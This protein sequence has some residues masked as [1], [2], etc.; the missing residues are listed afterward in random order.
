M[1]NIS[2]Y[3]RSH[4]NKKFD[5]DK[6]NFYFRGNIFYKNNYICP[7]ELYN[8]LSINLNENYIIEISKKLNGFYSWI[9]LNEKF[10]FLSVDHIRSLPLFYLIKNNYIFI[11]DETDWIR[12]HNNLK[13]IEES[14]EEE[15]KLSGLVSGRQTLFKE[16]RQLCP[17]EIL[18]INRCNSNS[19]LSREFFN[20]K[21]INDSYINKIELLNQLEEKSDK[22]FKRLI[23]FAKNRKIVIPLSGGYDSRLVAIKIKELGY[24]NVLTYSYGLRGNNDSEISKKVAK[25]LGFEWIFIKYDKNLWK[26]YWKD[27]Q[28]LK[29]QIW[30]SGFSSIPGIQEFPAIHF[31]KYNNIVPQDAL[32][33]PGHTGDFISGKHLPSFNKDEKF[34]NNNILAEIIFDKYYSNIPLF[35]LQNNKKKYWCKKILKSFNTINTKDLI[36]LC[37]GFESW[38]WKER[39]SKFIVNS[40]RTYEYF[41]FDWWLPLWDKEFVDFWKG[42]SLKYRYNQK[43][44]KVY[45][46]SK[47]ND[48]KLRIKNDSKINLII[49]IKIIKKII[50]C[51]RNL[52]KLSYLKNFYIFLV[53]LKRN[54]LLGIEGRYPI[55]N[56]LLYILKGYNYYGIAHNEFIKDLKKFLLK[57]FE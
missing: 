10:I 31:L 45:L 44:Y 7:E 9:L 54:N 20:F 17:G 49:R 36:S 14:S 50:R 48:D 2:I 39:Q 37:N 16:I 28:R 41:G 6:N 15:F 25:Q 35:N 26:K 3:L 34:I 51:F 21:Y 42:I 32:F 13:D 47:L 5:L 19:T 40:L 1:K 46:N 22:S 11:S 53:L 18:I 30:A 33:V 29:Y 4:K 55:H 12:K 23:S 24:K 52:F 38:D 43:L 8:K 57:G 27:R 56:Y